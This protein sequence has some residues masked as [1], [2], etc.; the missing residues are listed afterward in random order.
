MH[1]N[2]VGDVGIA[3][4]DLEQN[5]HHLEL[6]I[7]QSVVKGSVTLQCHNIQT[8]I[9]IMYRNLEN[10]RWQKYFFGTCQDYETKQIG[11]SFNTSSKQSNVS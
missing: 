11:N 2:L 3:A 9:N 8:Y 4:L 7:G 1:A 5:S 10:Y 6:G